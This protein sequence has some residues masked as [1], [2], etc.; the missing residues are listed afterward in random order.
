M[1]KIS[2]M[3]VMLSVMTCIS[4]SAA[5]N[6]EKIPLS[7]EWRF[8][9][10]PADEGVT[11]KWFDTTLPDSVM[12]PGSTDENGYGTPVAGADNLKLSR[13]KKYVGA[14]W[15]QREV[16]IPARWSGKRM[17]LLLERCGWETR[18]WVDG[19]EVSPM[20]N[21]L[22][23]AHEHD[24]SAALTPGKHTITICVDNTVKINIGHSHSSWLYTHAI[25]EETQTNWNGLIGR[26]E[27][28]VTDPV[29]V[30][31]VQVYPDVAAGKA[32]VK[33]RIGNRTGRAVSG[34]L[35]LHAALSAD[36]IPVVATIPFKANGEETTVEAVLG[37]GMF[38]AWDEF[39]P[40]LYDLTVTLATKG[41][42]KYKDVATT[43]FGM[44]D[45]AIDGQHF[46]MNGRRV[47]LRGTLDCCVW[48][49]TGHP[50]MD[51]E[52][53]VDYLQTLK[54]Y[55]HNHLRFHSW[56]PPTAAFIAADRLGMMFQVE[57]PL[58]D[59][60]GDMSN[61]PGL[62]PFLTAEIDRILDAYGNHPSFCL[63]STGNELGK[64]TDPFLGPSVEHNRNKDPRHFYTATTHPY[65]AKRN[66]DYF[67]AAATDRGIVRG[68]SAGP[69][70]WGTDSDH[71][72][73]LTGVDR[74]LVA[75]EIGQ[76]CMFANFDEIPKYTGVLRPRNMEIFRDSLEAHHMLDQ[77][78]DFR[79]AT[80]EFIERLYKEEYEKM[81]RTS[82]LS[83]F[84]SLG[85]YD[86]PG[87]GSTYIG[88]LD[89][90]RDSKGIIT[91]EEY[92]RF[93]DA[94]VLLLRMPRREWLDTETFAAD[95]EVSHYGPSNLDGLVVD[96]KLV[97][98][99]GGVQASGSLPAKEV[100]TG[101]LT[102]LGSLN[103]PLAE[104]IVPAKYTIKLSVSSPVVRN[105]WD[106]WVLSSSTAAPDA[107]DVQVL[108]DWEDG[109]SEAL[110]AG[111]K[112]LLLADP[113]RVN[114]PIQGRFLPVF[115]N[116][117]LF[118]NQSGTMSILLDPEH[119][120]FDG[121][122]TDS[123]SDWQWNDLLKHYKP[124]LLDDTLPDYRPLVQMIDDYGRNH[125]LG[126]VIEC[127][128]G[129][130]K[131]LVS[132]IDLRADMENRPVARH[133]LR[134][135][136]DY[137]NT[138]AFDPYMPLDEGF[139]EAMLTAPMVLDNGA[140]EHPERAVLDI[141]AAA[142]APAGVDAPW[143]QSQ[144]KAV[145]LS[146]GL[147][148]AITSARCWRDA[149]GSA[150]VGSAPEIEV[151]CPKGFKGTV[152]YHFHDWNNQKRRAHLYFEGNDMGPLV[153]YSGNGLWFSQKVSA[154]NSADG[155]IR[156]RAQ[157]TGGPNVM[158][159]RIVLLPN[160]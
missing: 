7:G 129:P 8:R 145:K 76:Y 46:T 130:G 27:L 29:W 55:G 11:D 61:T 139:L 136:L 54:D 2:I 52:T 119:P 133:L 70:G 19:R 108:K 23:V 74:P 25:T 103:I 120:A 123:H 35:K 10:D 63:F 122:P 31:A 84:Q 137:M 43:T 48:P 157:L 66:D 91:P 126:A 62:V 5:V 77:A 65:D 153:D 93:H 124:M 138:T 106:I 17:V 75:H 1:K 33:V 78:E 41:A 42:R 149:R 101:S 146:S 152:Y 28:I 86:F 147:D 158:I 13:V 64:G 128:V 96:W 45:F 56:C 88:L 127:R 58:W 40:A 37:M 107:G 67:V 32:R 30:E 82:N 115:W 14:A 69:D 140:P 89:A 68:I 143:S 151:A 150:W 100:Q 15:Y 21:S 98:Q 116:M 111:G 118:A 95:I 134:S 36:D 79:V 154:E 59:G 3:A 20:Q 109:V 94:T 53:W 6:P 144:D 72:A 38:S 85:I 18:V 60:Y 104:L 141:N 71:S 142:N 73:N 132:S 87:Q 156:L 83:G 12:L 50:P 22:C 9:L 135:L 4:A 117:R 121:F 26:V 57:G 97:D 51:V 92:R 34:A 24:L 148:Y 125:K 102:P 112:V 110:A 131:L 160:P 105:E 159:S 155:K 113:M 80:G 81:L 39:S 99:R 49:L 114:S 47:Y 90:F 44:R 16:T